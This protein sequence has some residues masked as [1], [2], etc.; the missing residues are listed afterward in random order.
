MITISPCVLRPDK[1]PQPRDV[2]SFTVPGVFQWQ[3]HGRSPKDIQNVIKVYFHCLLG[4]DRAIQSHPITLPKH[5]VRLGWLS[6]VCLTSMR[7]WVR[8]PS[9]HAN[10]CVW[11]WKDGSTGK[12]ACRVNRNLSSTQNPCERRDPAPKSSHLTSTCILGEHVHARTPFLSHMSAHDQRCLG[13]MLCACN[14][15]AGDTGTGES[16]GLLV[17]QYS[18]LVSY[19][20]EE[21]PCL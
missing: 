10:S 20:F 12:S 17:S 13:A 6:L 18:Q 2:V 7:I 4:G 9:I 1:T 11:R 8:V 3:A 16:W 14:P 5:C 15:S 21:R 19:R